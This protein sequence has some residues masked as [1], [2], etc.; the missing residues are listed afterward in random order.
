[1]PDARFF[2][3]IRNCLSALGLCS[4]QSAQEPRP[5]FRRINWGLHRVGNL[6]NSA[7]AMTRQNQVTAA[8]FESERIAAEK[9]EE[10]RVASMRREMR[11][12]ADIRISAERDALEAEISQLIAS[13]R[14]KLRQDALALINAERTAMEES[15]GDYLANERRLIE[16]AATELMSYEREVAFSSGSEIHSDDARGPQ[17]YEEKQGTW[18]S[19]KLHPVLTPEE[20]TAQI[21]K[22]KD[23]L[24]QEKAKD[25]EMLREL[26]RKLRSSNQPGPDYDEDVPSGRSFSHS[27]LISLDE[28]ERDR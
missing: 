20:L 11:R 5:G 12:H 16:Q 18:P 28:L 19:S 24:E 22:R 7:E 13:E 27:S 4:R 26:K 23:W 17:T 2:M 21:Q 14:N 9:L 15:I 6:N 8:L 1:M 25:L 10:E 3:F